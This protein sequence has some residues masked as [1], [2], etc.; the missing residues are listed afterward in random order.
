MNK[1][2]FQAIENRDEGIKTAVDHANDEHEKWS[3]Q[4]FDALKDFIER[5]EE[6][7]LGEDV[8]RFAVDVPIPPSKR[9][10][11]GVLVRA[12]RLGLIKKVGFKETTNPLAH[13]T[14]ATLW[15]KT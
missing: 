15:E 11:G 4:A 6:P 13:R 12:A 14:P 1:D 8:R 9:A 3:A 7:F 2:L 10:W 5:H